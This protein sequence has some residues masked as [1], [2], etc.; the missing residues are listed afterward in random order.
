MSAV[1]LAVGPTVSLRPSSWISPSTKPSIS[2]SSVPEISPFTRRL[3]PSHPVSRSAPASNGLVTSRGL[4]AS[5]LFLLHIE[6]SHGQHTQFPDG[7]HQ[8]DPPPQPAEIPCEFRRLA[9]RPFLQLVRF[10]SSVQSQ[11]RGSAR[12]AGGGR[13]INNLCCLTCVR[14]PENQER[15]IGVGPGSAVAIVDV[16]SR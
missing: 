16:D 10:V 2:R 7:V 8:L 13:M 11:F 14:D 3:D 9:L 1:T 5:V 15:C 12:R 6:S 4:I